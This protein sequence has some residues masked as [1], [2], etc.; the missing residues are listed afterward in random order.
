MPEN[1]PWPHFS[2]TELTCHCGCG[3]QE[4]DAQFMEKLEGLRVAYGRPMTLT[5][6]FRCPMHNSQASDTGLSG[7]HTTGKA[8]DVQVSGSDAHRLLTLALAQGFTGIGISQQGTLSARFLHLDTIE[9]GP[10]RPRPTLW[11]Y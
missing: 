7:P 11:T 10:G 3:R 8:V 5:S 4:M 1:T 6:A 9:P 2:Q